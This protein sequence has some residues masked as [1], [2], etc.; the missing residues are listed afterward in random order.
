MVSPVGHVQRDASIRRV[1]RFNVTCNPSAEWTA[2]QVVQT[3]IETPLLP[4]SGSSGLWVALDP[5]KNPRAEGGENT[6][7]NTQL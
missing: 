7:T 5:W 3:L 2:Q 4:R 1:L 6:G